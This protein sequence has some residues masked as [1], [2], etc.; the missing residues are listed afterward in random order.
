MSK[1]DHRDI[2]RLQAGPT[3]RTVQRDHVDPIK[4]G[5]DGTIFVNTA[6]LGTPP[7]SYD[8]TFA[9]VELRHNAISLFFGKEN[10]EDPHRLQSRLE[11]RYP[12]EGFVLHLVRNSRRFH[13]DIKKHL[14]LWSNRTPEAVQELSALHA[15]K[16]HSEWVNFDYISR[17]GSQASLD[18]FHLPPSG[19][20]RWVQGQGS[21]GVELV[22]KIRVLTTLTQL[23]ILLDSAVKLAEKVA[24]TL[25]AVFVGKLNEAI[26][27]EPPVEG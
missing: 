9:S 17:S 20:A 24:P 18:F 23:D 3:E 15:D 26:E 7:H 25:P 11:V 22:P 27:P 12:V 2:R 13:A 8:A 19:L 4:L 16:S 6:H 1:R 5:T 14:A 21:K 10:P